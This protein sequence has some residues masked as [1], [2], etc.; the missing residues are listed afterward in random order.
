MYSLPVNSFIHHLLAVMSGIDSVPLRS[1]DKDKK[2]PIQSTSSSSS[3][4]A[5]END[6]GDY[7]CKQF[8]Y[9]CFKYVDNWCH[10]RRVAWCCLIVAFVSTN[11]ASSSFVPTCNQ[12][13]ARVHEHDIDI[14]LTAIT[15]ILGCF[16]T[17][18]GIVRKLLNCCCPPGTMRSLQT[19]AI[20]L[21]HVYTVVG[22]EEDRRVISRCCHNTIGAAMATICGIW[23]LAVVITVAFRAQSFNGEQY[24][25]ISLGCH[26]LG[27]G[28]DQFITGYG[29]GWTVP[30]KCGCINQ[31]IEWTPKPGYPQLPGLVIQ[32]DGQLYWLRT[33]SVGDWTDG[34]PNQLS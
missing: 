23:S 5:N 17:L 26:H 13:D 27:V 30:D 1:D 21:A 20:R 8:I 19:T 6:V 14:V 22:D 32:P 11:Y 31:Y 25:G 24:K 10:A 9:A 18:S 7:T 28:P 16:V 15:I 33:P 2:S 29:S 34:N 12:D 3:S 4:G